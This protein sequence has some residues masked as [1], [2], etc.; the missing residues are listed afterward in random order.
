[1]RLNPRDA[2]RKG[3]GLSLLAAAL[4]VV[5]SAAAEAAPKDPPIVEQMRDEAQG[6][7]TVTESPATGRVSFVRASDDLFPSQRATRSAGGAEAKAAAY[8]E[9]YA[10]AFGGAGVELARTDVTESPAGYTVDFAQT[11]RGLP[12]FASR[13][14]AHVDREGDLTSV[15]GYVAPG[16][17]VATSPRLDRAAAVAKAKRL[18]TAAPAGGRDAPQVSGDLTVRTADLSIYRLGA[19]QGIAGR[20]L[21]AWVVEVTDGKQVRETVVLDA[22]TGKPVNRYSMIAHA[23]DRELYEK[24]VGTD[25]VWVE[26]DPFPGELDEDQRSEVQG[27]GEAYWFFMNSFGRDSFDDEGA[28]MITVNN[29]PTINCPNANWNG[30]STNYCSGVSSDDTVA[31]E[32]GHAYTEHTSGLLY[33]WQPGAMNEAY[34]DIWGETVDMLNDRQNQTP[35]GPRTVGDCSTYSL[36]IAISIVSPGEIARDCLAV[37]AARGPEFPETP[38]DVPLVPGVDAVET[39]DG[40]PIG[41]AYD[42]CSPFDNAADIA[43]KWVYIQEADISGCGTLS[44]SQSY[45]IQRQHAEAAGAVGIVMSSTDPWNMPNNTFDVPTAQIDAASGEAILSVDQPVTIRV[46]RAAGEGTITDSYR[47]LSGEGDPAFGG[48]IRDMWNPNCYGDPAKVSDEEYHC[49]TSDNGGVHSNSGVVNHTYA[50]LVDGGTYNGVTVEGIGLDK[51]AHLFW[52]TQTEYLTPVSGFVDLADGLEASCADLT[53]VTTLNRLAVGVS[54]TGGAEVPGT[55]MPAITADDCAEVADVIE[56]TQLRVE[57]VQCNF[58]LMF[59]KGTIGCGDGTVTQTLWSE[60][61][62]SGMPATWEKDI[63]AANASFDPTVTSALPPVTEGGTQHKGGP[64][65]LY[66]DDKGDDGSFGSCNADADDYSSRVSMATPPLIVPDGELP[67]LSFD[68]Y[69]ASEVTWDGGNV[70]VSVNGSDFAL[71]PDHAWLHNAPN[72]QLETTAG[73]NTN[74]MAGEPAFTGTDGGQPT[75]SWG[76][77][78][79][80]LT[81]VAEPGDTVRFRFDFGMDGCN[82]IDGWYVD[83]VALSVCA[84]P[85]VT[86]P[87]PGTAAVVPVAKAKKGTIKIR[88]VSGGPAPSGPVTVTIK[89]RTYTG[90][91]VNGVLRIKAKKQLAKLQKAGKRSVRAKVRYAGD[92]QVAP[93]S[94]TVKVLIKPRR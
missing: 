11:Y 2:L 65:V 21:L 26:G 33:Q 32:W 42:G 27:T 84:A 58:R 9:K 69:V 63:D 82:G 72:G 41:T 91:V 92:P 79:I 67:R 85:V 24:S 25:P 70:K 30:T 93:F 35:A 53:G 38:V 8:V 74:P 19:I 59:T 22:A 87:A 51:A 13:L 46:G 56:A 62:E 88:V 90:T 16:I 78:V 80:D 23:L 86:P 75:G 89:R 47:W 66:F 60:G 68:H 57:P 40:E 71:V 5:P 15:G 36:G 28:K 48:A 73:G 64:S 3:V 44:F 14:R 52:R 10:R 77:S 50:L 4:V 12:V 61:F 94:G 20:N 31:H 29:D 18:V 54:E 81:E 17:D 43:G 83:N 34:S 45:D 1:V 49:E 7:V 39:E 76:S 6:R 37:K 55:P